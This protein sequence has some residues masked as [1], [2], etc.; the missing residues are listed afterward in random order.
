MRRLVRPS[1]PQV[2]LTLQEGAFPSRGAPAGT[3]AVE[4]LG[5]S[6]AAAAGL[7]FAGYEEPEA[8]EVDLSKAEVIVGAGRGVGKKDNIPALAALARSLGGELGASRP[9]VDAGWVSHNRQVGA[10]GQVVSPRLYIACGIS[11]AIQHLAGMRNSGFIVA[12]NTDRDAPIAEVADVQ[13][14]ADVM[15]FVSALNEKLKR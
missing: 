13:V 1:T 14:V 2:V 6:A 7:E 9:V 3:P 12:V 8:R 10:T 4:K 5:P 11:G 15:P